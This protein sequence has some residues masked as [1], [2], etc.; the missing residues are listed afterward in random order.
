MNVNPTKIVNELVIALPYI[1]DIEDGRNFYHSWRVAII[2]ALSAMD[3][4]GPEDLK[5]TFYAAL[6]HDIGG[7][8]YPIHIIHYLKRRDKTSYNILLSHPI[9]G[10]Q[11]VSNLPQM[12]QVAKI[13]LDHHEWIN[14]QGYPRAKLGDS[15]P[16]SSQ[17]IR[18]ADSIDIHLQIN[19]IYN[20]KK[21]E[22]KLSVNIEREYPKGIF[23]DAF[24]I[25]KKGKLFD[26]IILRKNLPLIF[27]E[28]RDK[29]G[30]LKIPSKV[31]AVGKTLEF[32]AQVIDMKHPFT[33]GH[34]LRV[35]RYA[36]AIGLAMNL[37]HDEI[38][39]IRWAGLLH[40]IG[41]LSVSRRILDKPTRLNQEEYQKI[42]RHAHQTFATM[43]MIPTLK[44]IALIASAHHERFDGTGYPFGLK[45]DQIPPS[46]R[47]LAISDAFDAMTSNRPY[48]KPL[49]FEEACREIKKVSGKQF[50]PGIVN[51]ALPVFGSL[52]F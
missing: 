21:L 22:N 41:K 48:R 2:S 40:D 52:G 28:V 13:I 23:H 51:Y 35:S 42:Q 7:V 5:H 25:L 33:S 11:L 26:K 29:V 20:L 4:V 19:R 24:K 14:G 38:T 12:S 15:I 16:W 36:M 47:I 39:R 17:V 1:I 30:V 43:N 31:D 45:G 18:I 32:V 8:G 6:L 10:A 27:K 49:T 44:D 9:I 34:S 37:D 46:A 3:S 50:D